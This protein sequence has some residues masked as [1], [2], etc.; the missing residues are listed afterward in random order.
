MALKVSGGQAD[1]WRALWPQMMFL[2]VILLAGFLRRGVP[3][4]WLAMTAKGFVL[5]AVSTVQVLQ[6]GNVGYP[7]MIARTLLP[8]FVAVAALVL[9]AKQ[10]MGWAA[11]Q[12]RM[13]AGRGRRTLPDGT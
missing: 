10:A 8:Q 13:P 9:A 3:V 12:H 1:L 5:S 7:L 4:V 6:Q 2:G 11:L